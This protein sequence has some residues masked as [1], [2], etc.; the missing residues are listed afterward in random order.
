[1]PEWIIVSLR[2]LLAVV[3]LFFMTK[4]L[5]KRQVSEL[6]L[7]EYITGI[8][9]G[10][11]AASICLDL[12]TSWYLGV[13]SLVIWSGITIGIEYLQLKSKKA[14]DFIDHRGTVLIQN[15]KILEDNLK[16]IRIT[17][18][19]LLTRLRQKNMFKVADVEFA[20]MEPNGDI[21]VFPTKENQPL[22]P[23]DLGIQ[24]P[25]ETVPQTVIM[26]GKI[27]DHSL[28][29]LGLNRRWLHTELDKAGVTVENVFLG[30][31]DDMGELYL[32]LFDDTIQVPKPKTRQLL[33]ATLQKALAD[34]K[35]FALD[36][37]DP[38]AKKMYRAC[39]EK[40]EQVIAKVK[41]R[42]Q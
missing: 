26:D 14:R 40:L 34:V 11:I 38:K 27:L 7:F 21:N 18:D 31:V 13:L 22:T 1:M 19:E 25:H 17:S 8:T 37:N 5:G 30:Q 39:Q 28:N 15:G 6:S 29:N 33:L 41:P 24:I 35:G 16:K 2:T 3:V 10:S 20:I 42:L 23:K 32:D 36:T 9:I 12:N 4:L